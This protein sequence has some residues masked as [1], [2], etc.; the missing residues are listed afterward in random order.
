MQSSQRDAFIAG[1]KAA[2]RHTTM[3]PEEINRLAQEAWN[4]VCLIKE[5]RFV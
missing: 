4:Q 1:F 5:L 2:Y 3:K